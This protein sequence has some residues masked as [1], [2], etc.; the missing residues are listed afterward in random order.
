MIAFFYESVRKLK[1]EDRFYWKFLYKVNKVLVN[2]C[3]PVCQ[4]WRRGDGTDRQSRI[5]VSLTTY[6][7]R[8]NSVWITVSSL[9]QQTMKPYK[10]I[11]W[12]G[13]GICFHPPLRCARLNL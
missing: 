10:V 1:K 4:Y 2:M 8:I 3:F 5:I 13:G 6:P 7:A 12:L 11:L 9:L